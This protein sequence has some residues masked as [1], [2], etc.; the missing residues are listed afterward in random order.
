VRGHLTAY[1]ALRVI[2][3]RFNTG[4]DSEGPTPNPPIRRI[5]RNLRSTERCPAAAGRLGFR[6]SGRGWSSTAPTAGAGQSRTST[7]RQPMTRAR[8][9]ECRHGRPASAQS[10]PRRGGMAPT[11][12]SRRP[13]RPGRGRAGTLDRTGL[14]TRSTDHR[15]FRRGNTPGD[16]RARL[17][18]RF[19][20]DLPFLILGR[21]DDL[22]RSI[23]TGIPAGGSPPSPAGSRPANNSA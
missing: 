22:P 6:D 3:W 17:I 21:R 7:G 1:D 19:Q 16:L 18:Y 11:R 10:R 8:C 9:A 13:D 23:G 4:P 15:D 14:P 12:I 20:R 2:V 5:G